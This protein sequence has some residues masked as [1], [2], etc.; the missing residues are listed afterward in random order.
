MTSLNRIHNKIR[1]TKTIAICR[2][3]LHDRVTQDWS[4]V[5]IIG[6]SHATRLNDFYKISIVRVCLRKASLLARFK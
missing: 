3:D 1:V 5:T 2:A 6:G 4:S